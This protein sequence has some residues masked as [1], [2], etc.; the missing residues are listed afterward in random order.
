MSPRRAVL[1]ALCAVL[2]A[3][4]A[5]QAAFPQDGKR[6]RQVN[7]TRGVTVAGLAAV[8]PR[9]G[10]GRCGAP[11]DGWIWATDAQVVALFGHYVPDIL[12]ADPPSVGGAGYLFAAATFLGDMRP[13]FSFSGYS[14]STESVHGWTADGSSAGVSAGR[15]RSSTPASASGR[16]RTS[17][18]RC[19]ARGCGGRAPTTSRSRW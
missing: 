7:E 15:T 17:R 12:T 10:A 18:A 9:D 6:W 11:H 19:A 5:A 14:H 13:T 4:S 2:S 16:R 3:P 1:L 8:C